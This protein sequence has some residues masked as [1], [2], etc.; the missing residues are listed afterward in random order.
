MPPEL[1]PWMEVEPMGEATLVR[2][3]RRQLWGD[4]VRS[5]GAAL[6]R[7]VDPGGQ[8]RIVLSLA[9]VERLDSA[10]LGHILLLHRRAQEAGGRLALCRLT[11][12]LYELFQ[13]VQLTGFLSIYGD[14]SEALLAV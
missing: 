5:L 3:T 4:E 12:E 1:H 13:L 14:E 10:M 7:L 11:P 9:G 2:F 8:R 6:H